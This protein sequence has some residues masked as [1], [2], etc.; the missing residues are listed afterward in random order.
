MNFPLLGTF[1]TILW[2]FL[3]IIWLA[4]V[5]W[6]TIDVFRDDRLS[7][8]AK[9]GWLVAIL[10]LPLLGTVIYLIARGDRRGAGDSGT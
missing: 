10:V 2:F 3:L 8:G 1:L 4:L 6:T 5:M 7:G 9:A